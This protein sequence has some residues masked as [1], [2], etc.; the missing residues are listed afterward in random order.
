M[1]LILA[2]LLALLVFLLA[3]AL[4]AQND[5]LVQVNYLIAQSQL[6]LSALMAICFVG[7]VAVTVAIWLLWFMGYRLKVRRRARVA[8]TSPGS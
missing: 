7:G 8:N 2:L 5:Q 3:L 4:G 1:K 6:P